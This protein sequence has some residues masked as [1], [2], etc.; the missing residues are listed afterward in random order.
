MSMSRYEIFRNFVLNFGH[1]DIYICFGFRISCF[2]FLVFLLTS[3]SC[4][5]DCIWFSFIFYILS[6]DFYILFFHLHFLGDNLYQLRPVPTSDNLIFL[7]FKDVPILRSNRAR[8]R[9]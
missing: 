6:S 5:L 1:L 9:L 8:E 7:D 2:G 3:G 4:L